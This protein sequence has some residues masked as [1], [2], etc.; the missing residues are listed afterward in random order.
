MLWIAV[1]FLLFFWVVGVASSHTFA[2]Y[3]N[4]LY[5]LACVLAIVGIVLKRRVV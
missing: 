4:I 2:G 3:I 1:V 5:A